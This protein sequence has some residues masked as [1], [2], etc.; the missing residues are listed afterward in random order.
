MLGSEQ[1]NNL[2]GWYVNKIEWV[3]EGGY[4]NKK[5]ANMGRIAGPHFDYF[6]IT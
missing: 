4:K 1:V 5:S 3:G 2:R 6:V